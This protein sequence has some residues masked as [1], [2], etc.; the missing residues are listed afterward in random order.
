MV[1]IGLALCS[2]AYAQDD[3]VDLEFYRDHTYFEAKKGALGSFLQDN[4]RS[5]TSSM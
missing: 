4:W 1:L 3:Y 5:F 2:S